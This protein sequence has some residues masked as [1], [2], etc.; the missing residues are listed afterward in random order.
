MTAPGTQREVRTDTT[1]WDRF[2]PSPGLPVKASGKLAFKAT[3]GKF[4]ELLRSFTVDDAVVLLAAGAARDALKGNV[5]ATQGNSAL[6]S[7][8]YVRQTDVQAFLDVYSCHDSWRVLSTP[9]GVASED[10]RRALD[11]AEYASLTSARRAKRVAAEQGGDES[12][13]W[14]GRDV[15]S[16]R[17]RLADIVAMGDK[18]VHG[19]PHVYGPVLR[20]LA[21]GRGRMSAAELGLMVEGT[22]V[23]GRSGRDVYVGTMVRVAHR[24]GEQFIR[25]LHDPEAVRSVL[26]VVESDPDDA[27]VLPLLT[28]ADA[29]GLPPDL[30]SE[31]ESEW[32]ESGYG[33]LHVFR[34]EA[35]IE[36]WEAGIAAEN[37]KRMLGD[38]MTAKQIIAILTEGVAPGLADGWL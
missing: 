35:V 14:F 12:E 4:C 20:D 11:A 1:E 15:R 24:F 18:E 5:P 7:E 37:A 9:E 16:G 25:S 17:I 29:V 30:L 27:R 21:A 23:Y 33:R 8:L 6:A 22:N 3:A 26:D 34:A 32:V 36:L 38:D 31:G 10:G 2:A 13:L 28:Y 19:L